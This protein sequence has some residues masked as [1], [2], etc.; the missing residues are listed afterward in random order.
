MVIGHL[1]YFL[2]LLSDI[3]SSSSTDDKT[4]T[5]IVRKVKNPGV[6]SKSQ[7]EK[8]NGVDPAQKNDKTPLAKQEIQTIYHSLTSE[9]LLEK[10]VTG[11]PQNTKEAPHQDIWF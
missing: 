11:K 5:K 7:L 4:N 8:A 10:C 1:C 6:Y 3:P 2:P 9:S